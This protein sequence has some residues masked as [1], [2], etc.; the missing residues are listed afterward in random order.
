M[1]WPGIPIQA[2]P[3]SLEANRWI[4][5]MAAANPPRESSRLSASKN[6]I[7]LFGKAVFGIA[8]RIPAIASPAI[9][10]DASRTPFRLAASERLLRRWEMRPPRK[11]GTITA[12]GRYI[13]TATGMTCARN[14]LPA[15]FRK[16]SST[17][18][19]IAMNPPIHTMFQGRSESPNNAFAIEANRVACGA[20][21][22]PSASVPIP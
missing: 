17:T 3:V 5:T 9:R 21:N 20:R 7:A 8:I 4:R 16:P 19:P 15:R 13:P 6:G 11:I 2:D 14:R 22:A 10:P 12:I 1:T 18:R